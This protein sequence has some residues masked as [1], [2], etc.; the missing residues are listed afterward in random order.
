MT[1]LLVGLSFVTFYCGLAVG[2]WMAGR[3]NTQRDER[4]VQFTQTLPMLD[5]SFDAHT[6]PRKV[7]A[8]F[9]RA[10]LDRMR[11]TVEPNHRGG[12]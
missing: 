4:L 1:V 9:S 11:G 7:L 10:E 6:P 5:A 3:V 8:E 12:F 2:V